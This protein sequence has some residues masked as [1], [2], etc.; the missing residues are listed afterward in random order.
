MAEKLTAD[1][2]KWQVLLIPPPSMAQFR[3]AHRWSPTHSKKRKGK[4]LV[5]QPGCVRA[6]VSGLALTR[7]PQGPLRSLPSA[8]RTRRGPVSIPCPLADFTYPQ[9]EVGASVYC[10]SGTLHVLLAF[11]FI[12]SITLRP[13]LLFAF[14]Q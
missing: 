9:R 4:E 2:P 8:G 13:E 11:V 3:K 7:A 6:A 5:R 1:V 10:A 12:F 14:Y